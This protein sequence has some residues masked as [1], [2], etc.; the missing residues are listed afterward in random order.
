M[1]DPESVGA[2]SNKFI[3]KAKFVV[4]YLKHLEVME[5]KKKKRAEERARESQKT[6]EKVYADYAWKD[7]CE[8]STKLKQL[9]V[10]ELNKY[11]RHHGIHQHIKSAKNDKVK[12]IAR[13]WLLQ[14][15]PEGPDPLMLQTRLRER[16][17]ADKESLQDSD[18]DEDE[19]SRS[20]STD[21]DRNDND[22]INS[23]SDDVI[24]AFIDDEEEVERPAVTRSGR[25]INRRSEIDFS[26]F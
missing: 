18:S 3:V 11:L 10:S 17:G 5:F 4:D 25:S 19:H 14:M 13:H 7:L 21:N 22:S 26:F 2:F 23:G 15:N 24:L 1:S 8:D 20:E 12:V 9:R 6:K 16:D